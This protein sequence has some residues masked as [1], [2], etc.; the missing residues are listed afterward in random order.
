MYISFDGHLSFSDNPP[1]SIYL[2]FSIN[3]IILTYV[4]RQLH[5]MDKLILDHQLEPSEIKLCSNNAKRLS[6]S[7][8][9]AD[10]WRVNVY[11][12]YL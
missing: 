12:D 2:T 10:L 5:P 6:A 11:T 3:T 9:Y 8:M 4:L 1:G 7:L